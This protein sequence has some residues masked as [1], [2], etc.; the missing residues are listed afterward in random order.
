[1]SNDQRPIMS[2]LQLEILLEAYYK[3]FMGDSRFGFY[4]DHP[5]ANVVAPAVR[6]AISN[7]KHLQLLRTYHTGHWS[8]TETGCGLVERIL[9]ASYDALSNIEK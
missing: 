5:V 7:F 6:E 1:M 3:P 2:P 4:T 9:V 8:I